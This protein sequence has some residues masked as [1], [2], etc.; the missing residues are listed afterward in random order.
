MAFALQVLGHC[1]ASLQLPFT[2]FTI[3]RLF[4]AFLHRRCLRRFLWLRFLSL[5]SLLRFTAIK[6]FHHHVDDVVFRV[7]MVRDHFEPESLVEALAA[8]VRR[9][10]VYLGAECVDFVPAQASFQVRVEHRANAQVLVVVINHDPINIHEIV[11]AL[12]RM[13]Q[14]VFRIVVDTLPMGHHERHDHPLILHYESVQSSR[15]QVLELLQCDFPNSLD[16]RVVQFP[17]LCE[18]RFCHVD[19]HWL[20]WFLRSVLGLSRLE[21]WLRLQ[22]AL[23]MVEHHHRVVTCVGVVTAKL[24]VRGEFVTA[25]LTRTALQVTRLSDVISQLSS[26]LKLGPANEAL[27]RG[28]L[29]LLLFLHWLLVV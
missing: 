17:H 5:N 15:K 11:V 12:A 29:L 13:P 1:L 3:L 28:L 6:L 8:W 25:Y 23:L 14:V 26:A 20:E 9:H 18:V 10:T 7:C 16:M 2:D 4:F 27:F 22:C 19:D 24:L 21:G